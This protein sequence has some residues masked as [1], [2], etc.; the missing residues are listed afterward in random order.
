MKKAVKQLLSYPRSLQSFDQ[1]EEQASKF[2]Y[3]FTRYKIPNG[4]EGELI[5]PP[6]GISPYCKD[7]KIY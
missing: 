4:I 2:V 6:G 3:D 5:I 1:T 7:I